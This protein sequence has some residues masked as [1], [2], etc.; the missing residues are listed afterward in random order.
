MTREIK[1]IM[2]KDA[3]LKVLDEIKNK[4]YE[5]D[6]DELCG[7]KVTIKNDAE[8]ELLKNMVQGVMCGL[9]YWDD[10]K[11]CLAQE[12]I[13]PIK[14]GEIEKTHLYYTNDITLGDTKGFNAENQSDL[15]IK[16]LA[17]ITANGFQVIE[18]LKKADLSIATALC[19][20]FDR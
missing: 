15:V 11:N 4:L 14:A 17:H 3:A 9:V 19:R 5:V 7:D 13:Y 16:A 20:F 12:L 2:E 6:L 1:K 8:N 18:R 10:N